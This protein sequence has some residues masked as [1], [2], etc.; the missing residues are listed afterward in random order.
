MFGNKYSAFPCRNGKCTLPPSLVWAL[1]LN[2]E[3]KTQN[4]KSNHYQAQASDSAS[5]I[6]DP[7]QTQNYLIH[8]APCV[9]W[10][11][12]PAVM[13]VVQRI[14][15]LLLDGSSQEALH[16]ESTLHIDD[17]LAEPGSS[18][19]KGLTSQASMRSVKPL[20]MLSSESVL[21]CKPAS[22]TDAI[23]RSRSR[24]SSASRIACRSGMHIIV[25]PSPKIP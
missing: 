25:S 1:T 9:Y 5:L 17:C 3:P 21:G 8:L 10:Q 19:K 20:A 18:W 7:G 12:Q 23:S 13:M 24:L 14:L 15:S 11:G 22:S 4:P 16:V 2:P 6:A